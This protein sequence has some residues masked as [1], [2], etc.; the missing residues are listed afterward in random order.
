[1]AYLYA[2]ASDWD[3]PLIDLDNVAVDLKP[4]TLGR[5]IAPISEPV[6]T[7]PVRGRLGS[8]RV[9]GDGQIDHQWV[10]PVLPLAALHHI[11]DSKLT[12]SSV[13]VTSKQVTIYTPQHELEQYARFNTWLTLP[14]PGT[15]YRIRRGFA[16][17]LVLRFTNLRLLV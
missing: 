16:M 14:K 6:D 10:F 9:R 5:L 7:F 2:W 17:D 8:G 3:V 12:T 11:I 1:M 15:D 4:H 13:I